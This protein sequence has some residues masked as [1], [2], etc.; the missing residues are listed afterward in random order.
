MLETATEEEHGGNS[1]FTAGGFR[2]THAG[3]DDRNRCEGPTSRREGEESEA[4]R[5]NT[6]WARDG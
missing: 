3:L 5:L 4:V 6:G 1:V 2:F